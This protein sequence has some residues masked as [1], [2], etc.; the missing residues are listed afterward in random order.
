MS[1]KTIVKYARAIGKKVAVVL[2][3][4]DDYANNSGPVNSE[5]F[6][7]AWE[8]IGRPRDFF[9]LETATTA[10]TIRYIVVSPMPVRLNGST[11]RY[12]DNA[13]HSA[14]WQ[15]TFLGF[16]SSTSGEVRGI[17]SRAQAI[18]LRQGI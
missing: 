2:Y 14:P 11:T 18:E 13:L 9:E 10:R 1:L 16:P 8:S 17:E 5:I 6:Y 7:R 15:T 3:D 4:D 12:W